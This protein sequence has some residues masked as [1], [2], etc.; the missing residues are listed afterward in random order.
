MSWSVSAKRG[1]P[2]KKQSSWNSNAKST[3]LNQFKKDG[4]GYSSAAKGAFLLY[5]SEKSDTQDG[6]KLPFAV[7]SNG[8]ITGASSA[9]LAAA[10]RRLPQVKGV[11]A[12]TLKKARGV[13][14]SYQKKMKESDMKELDVDVN[15]FM[16]E[17]RTAFNKRFKLRSEV[18]DSEVV[19]GYMYVEDVYIDHPML[20]NSVVVDK[21]GQYWQVDY[22]MSDNVPVFADPT[23]WVRVFRTYMPVATPAAEVA[24]AGD[25]SEMVEL[26]EAHASAVLGI[27]EEESA[28]GPLQLNVAIIEPGWGNQRDNNYYPKEMLERDAKVFQGAKMYAT[29]HRASE[30]SVLTEVSQ[31]LE[32]PVG[33]TETGAPIARVGV[34]SEAFAESIRNRNKLGV[35]S[36]LHCSILANGKVQ[37]GFESDGRKGRKVLSITEAA[38]VD[39]VTRHGAGG[40]ALSIAESDVMLMEAQMSEHDD[41]LD[42]E[43]TA[44]AAEEANVEEAALIEEETTPAT[45]DDVETSDEEQAPDTDEA[46]VADEAPAEE[47]FLAESDVTAIVGEVK[48]LPEPTRK[49]LLSEKYH[50]RYEVISAIEAEQTYLKMITD[51]GKPPIVGESGKDTGLS[52]ADV[53]KKKSDV[54]SRYLPS[55]RR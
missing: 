1:L 15:T 10:A 5:N 30:K 2:I 4:G 7:V 20:G 38:S 35:L 13:I 27:L 44:S 25:D 12:D 55:M 8:K 17:I 6:Y 37:T 54:N 48:N 26:G 53:A 16:R 39:W 9:G 45:S 23:Q 29:N 36:D 11:P 28:E 19:G 24:D 50:S 46:D 52:E 31:I 22:E 40:R 49:R 21:S 43:A 14:D 34:F 33:F 18:V 41:V 32:C 47:Q 3:I 42:T 51:S